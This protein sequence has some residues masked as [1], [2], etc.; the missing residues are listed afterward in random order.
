MSKSNGLA[1]ISVFHN[2]LFRL[3]EFKQYVGE[4]L[5]SVDKHIIISNGDRSNY[6]VLRSKF[7]KSHI[8][9]CT[10][11]WLT[12][13][14]NLG[15]DF[16]LKD[17]EI[18]YIAV[19]AND[20]TMTAEGLHDLIRECERLNADVIGPTILNSAGRVES[21]G[22]TIDRK[23]VS[24]VHNYKGKKIEDLPCY[25]EVD[26]LP[27]G[28]F[29]LTRKALQIFGRQDER[30]KMYAD[31]IDFGLRTTN[32]KKIVTSKVTSSHLHKFPPGYICRSP[33][34][35]YLVSR[36]SIYLAKKHDITSLHPLVFYHLQTGIRKV[37]AAVIKYRSWEYVKYAIAY[38]KG[39]YTVFKNLEDE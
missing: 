10:S 39:I 16:A 31:E 14:V 4:Y 11:G 27:G 9:Q 25:Q 15:F 19:V 6:K 21:F 8:V 23:R 38:I 37:L 32:L 24:I 17:P 36:N 13:A 12:S 2:E 7:T 18:G 22:Q 35:G 30:L 29:I 34:S 5:S 28:F 20:F 3:D 33:L 1:V 26:T